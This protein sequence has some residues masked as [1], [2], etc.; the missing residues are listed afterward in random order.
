MTDDLDAE[1]RAT[2]D[3][4]AAVKR[5]SARVATT[6]TVP[7][8]PTPR[9]TFNLAPVFALLDE[10]R[11]LPRCL[12]DARARLELSSVVDVKKV[13]VVAASRRWLVEALTRQFQS[14]HYIASHVAIP[15]LVVA[16][17]RAFFRNSPYPRDSAE[18]E[19]DSP[20][21][22]ARGRLVATGVNPRERANL[23]W[24]AFELVARA[25]DAG[26]GYDELAGL[27]AHALDMATPRAQLLAAEM[28]AVWPRNIDG[29]TSVWP[30]AV[31]WLESAPPKS[32]PVTTV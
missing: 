22:D 1:L 7:P 24:K 23:R 8:P 3:K 31:R 13:D 4:L 27:L 9:P 16:R 6:P 30:L 32:I 20:N 11:A 19:P 26:R 21:W 25:G 5:K 29:E 10:L 12:L 15:A 14:R 17:D 2:R 28:F 18:R